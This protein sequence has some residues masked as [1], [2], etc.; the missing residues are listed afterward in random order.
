MEICIDIETLS[1]RKNAY[2]LS[3]GA[4]R[5]DRDEIKEMFYVSLNNDNQ[6]HRHLDINTIQWWLQQSQEAMQK[7]R[8]TIVS[9]GDSI[10]QTTSAPYA[11]RKLA[12]FIG[13][14]SSVSVWANSPSFD[15][16][17]LSDAYDQFGIRR[18]WKYSQERDVRTAKQLVGEPEFVGIKH[19]ALDD[20]IHEARIVQRYLKLGDHS[21]DTRG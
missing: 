6:S 18:P 3:I 5:F 1:L 8:H 9:T 17:I 16:D 21:D 15:C 20:A 19:Y 13:L 2:I 10:A 11:L 14:N 12:E 4:V 7:L